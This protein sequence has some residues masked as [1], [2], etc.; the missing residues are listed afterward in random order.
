MYVHSPQTLFREAGRVGDAGQ[1]SVP[2][3][4]QSGHFV[5]F[6]C[7]LFKVYMVRA[8]TVQFLSLTFLAL[9]WVVEQ[10]MTNKEE[11]FRKQRWL[12]NWQNK[13]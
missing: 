1:S 11:P 2:F 12:V 5:P 7:L 6:A 4:R 3:Q 8:A 9:S 13:K 10:C